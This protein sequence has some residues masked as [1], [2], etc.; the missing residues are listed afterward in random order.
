M[1]LMFQEHKQWLD[2][3]QIPGD[4][5]IGTM[6]SA[7]LDTWRQRAWDKARFDMA[8]NEKGP[9]AF[10]RTLMYAKPFLISLRDV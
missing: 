8:A 7:P 4:D 3:L 1:W 9:L 6:V 10:F 5:E 2:S